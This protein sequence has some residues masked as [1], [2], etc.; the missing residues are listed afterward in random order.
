MK[1]DGIDEDEARRHVWLY[2]KNGLI[3]SEREGL[4]D[5]QQPFAHEHEAVDDFVKAIEDLKPTAIIGVSTVAKAF[6]RQVI[7]TMAKLNERP[8]IFPYS[9]PTS[10]A[11]CTAKEAYE[12]SKGKAVFASGS[13]FGPV[14]LGDQTFIPG[15]G[16]NVYIFPAMG[17]A[18]YATEAKRV[19]DAMFIVAAKA[20]SDQVTEANL[21]VGLIYPPQHDILKVSLK[22]AAAVAQFVFDEGLAGVD[23][24]DDV[25]AFIAAKAYTPEYSSRG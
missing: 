22:V 14:H 9:N 11:E 10:R 21:K 4:A 24:P 19:T 25:E 3:Q 15:Q 7:E 1:A 8:I 13:P 16:N 5:F 2:D 18:I 12:W 17:M 23:A 6:N 20:L